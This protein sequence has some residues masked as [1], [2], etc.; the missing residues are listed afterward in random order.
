MRTA[1]SSG[2]RYTAV[3]TDQ[4]TATTY[5]AALA[6]T[7]LV[8]VAL[9]LMD[10]YSLESLDFALRTSGRAAFLV[11]I[12]VFAARPLQV[13]LQKPWTGKLLRNRRQWGVAFAGIHTAHLGL[14]FYKTQVVPDF[15]LR[16]ILNLPAAV[17]YG[18]MLAMLVTSFSGPARAIGPKAWKVVHKSGL[19]VLF[20]AF[21]QSQIPQQLDQLETANG[22]LIGLAVL[23]VAL[24]AGAFVKRRRR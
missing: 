17:V 5:L 8:A 23:A 10:G 9:H 11:L 22:F 3:T 15:A 1:V 6:L 21:L 13:L 19:F 20:F 12:V 16:A 24:R 14:I 18:L 7:V 2:N 4:R